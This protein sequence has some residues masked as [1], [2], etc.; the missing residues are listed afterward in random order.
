MESF[1]YSKL[2]YADVVLLPVLVGDDIVFLRDEPVFY[3][4]EPFGCGERFNWF[5]IIDDCSRVGVQRVRDKVFL[6]FYV[7][8]ED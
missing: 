2:A 6:G 5:I 7:V 1:S 4:D 3:T 8:W